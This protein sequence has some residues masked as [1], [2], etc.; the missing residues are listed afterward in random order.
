MCRC[1][2]I[3]VL[4]SQV[5]DGDG[6]QIQL[7]RLPMVPIIKRNMYARLCACIEQSTLLSIFSNHSSEIV[8]SYA[9]S[10]LCPGLPIIMSFEEIRLEVIRFVAGRGKVGRCCIERRRFDN[11]DQGPFGQIRGSHIL[12]CLA[13]ISRDMYQTIIRACPEKPL[14]QW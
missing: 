6:R 3:A 8:C 10:D 5:V 7:Q 11:T 13:V 14:L 1:D 4:D 2:E 9:R 12:P